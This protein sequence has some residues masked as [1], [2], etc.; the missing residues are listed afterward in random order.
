MVAVVCELWLS[1][2]GSE[3]VQSRDGYEVDFAEMR[4]VIEKH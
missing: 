2:F 3:P 4:A 1:D